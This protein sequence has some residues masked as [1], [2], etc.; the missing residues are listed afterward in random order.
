MIDYR[1]IPL[2][3]STVLLNYP[4]CFLFAIMV[5][6]AAGDVLMFLELLKCKDAKLIIDHPTEPAFY[7]IYDNEL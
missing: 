7:V 6:G 5:S 4:Y 2:V 1:I 3:I